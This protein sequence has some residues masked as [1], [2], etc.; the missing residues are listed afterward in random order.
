MLPQQDQLEKVQAEHE[1]APGPQV[2]RSKPD[3]FYQPQDRTRGE[4]RELGALILFCRWQSC[5]RPLLPRNLA[6]P[7]CTP[8]L[9]RAVRF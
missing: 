5:P 6:L 4:A 2:A 8:H 3:R 1:A 7:S 9:Q